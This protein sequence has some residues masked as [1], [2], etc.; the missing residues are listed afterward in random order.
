MEAT[1]GN[2]GGSVGRIRYGRHSGGDGLAFGKCGPAA[3]VA[4]IREPEEVEAAHCRSAEGTNKRQHTVNPT[5]KP[6]PPNRTALRFAFIR[7]LTGNLT[8]C[9]YPFLAFPG[10]FG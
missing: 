5:Q 3:G 10:S 8:P 9:S 2:L 1:P 6:A 7:Y 4:I